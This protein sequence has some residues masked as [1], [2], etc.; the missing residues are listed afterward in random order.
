MKERPFIHISF[1]LER[2]A[3]YNLLRA[4]KAAKISRSKFLRNIVQEQIN[5]SQDNQLKN[6]QK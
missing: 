1:R 2:P 6:S 3:Y 5:R 4:V